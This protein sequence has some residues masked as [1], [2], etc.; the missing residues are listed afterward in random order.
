MGITGI[1]P[2]T[3]AIPEDE[4][5]ARNSL[6]FEYH[7]W[8]GAIFFP[9]SIAVAI[10]ACLCLLAGPPDSPLPATRRGGQLKTK[11]RILR[12]KFLGI[13]HKWCEINCQN[14]P[15]T[16]INIV[17]IQIIGLRKFPCGGNFCN[18]KKMFDVQ[19]WHVS[20][21][22]DNVAPDLEGVVGPVTVVTKRVR[23]T[24]NLIHLARWQLRGATSASGMCC[25]V[26]GT[27]DSA[28]VCQDFDKNAKCGLG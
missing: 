20:E 15:D 28:Y 22:C 12:K 1:A 4:A 10:G 8:I 24:L 26:P 27:K 18:V 5:E 2:C 23:I 14:Y 3:W 16:W 9:Q 17:I 6:I 25:W 11:L 19:G 7:T 21:E 13:S